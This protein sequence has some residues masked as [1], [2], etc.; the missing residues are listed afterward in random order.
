[1]SQLQILVSEDFKQV[2]STATDRVVIAVGK[3]AVLRLKLGQEWHQSQHFGQRVTQVFQT[4]GIR[5]KPFG[6]VLQDRAVKSEWAA[7]EMSADDAKRLA[8]VKGENKKFDAKWRVLVL[9][10][11][12]KKRRPGICVPGPRPLRRG[13]LVKLLDVLRRSGRSS[14]PAVQYCL[15]R[16][17]FQLSVYAGCRCPA[18]A[19]PFAPEF[20][21][22]FHPCV[23]VKMLCAAKEP[24]RPPVGVWSCTSRMTP[25]YHNF[26]FRGENSP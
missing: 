4:L 16:P 11:T 24:C 13:R 18:G 5:A 1:M 9:T 7:F 6:Y 19:A 2:A 21:C 17:V 10:L 15:L 12:V 8:S 3:R 14:P 26:A 23:F 25:P 20:R 22:Q